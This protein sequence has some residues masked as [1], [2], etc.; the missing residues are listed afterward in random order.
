[1]SSRWTGFTVCLAAGVF[2]TSLSA[3]AAEKAHKESHK[4]PEKAAAAPVAPSGPSVIVVGAGM[5]GLASAYE[6]QQAGWN[7]TLL[8][9]GARVGG[10]SGLASSEWI[11][12]TKAQPVL[13]HYLDTFK[14]KTVDAPSFVRT[15][16]YLIDGQYYSQ[17]DLVQKMPAVADA[18]KRVDKSLDDLAAAI[19]DPLQPTATPTLHALDQI[20]AATWLDK[21]NLPPVARQLINQRIRVRYDEPS[22]LSLLYLAQQTRV[23]RGVEDKDLRASR[24]PG[25]SDV[26]AQAF[27]KQIKTIKTDS[28]VSSI[29]QDPSGV[30]VKAGANG[31]KA[32]YVVM[33]VPLRALG[34]V[35]MTPT[36]DATQQAAIKGTTYGWRDQ[37]L[38]KFKTPVWDSK[39]RM[40]GEIYSDQG[41]GMLW[42]EPDVKGG[43]NVLVN[44]AGDSARLVQAFGDKQ[45]VDQVLIRFHALYPKARGAFSGYEV[46]RYSRDPGVGGTYLA[47]GPGQI[48]RYWRLWEKPTGRVIFAGE[49]TDPL[50]PGTLEGALASGQRAAGQVRDLKAGKAVVPV[51]ASAKAPAQPAAAP[52]PD[53]AAPAKDSGEHGFFWKLFHWSF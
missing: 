8:E 46:R 1:M 37:I 38:L 25:G 17:D 50:H 47:Y 18:L 43:A 36:L 21:Q 20:N 28:K 14:L 44:L 7:V 45:M 10:R 5:A 4:A 32:D 24:L 13:N 27:V 40:S 11:G 31:Y 41:L 48:T 19:S 29:V 26:L 33:A 52:K 23:Y 39:S 2:A 51:V 34:Q 9:A 15:P 22:R 16:G 3:G 35:Q 42:V 12:D 6:L 53:D 49:H 30:T